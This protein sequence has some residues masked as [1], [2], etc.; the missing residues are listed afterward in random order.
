MPPRAKTTARTPS[1]SSTPLAEPLDLDA[2]DVDLAEQVDDAETSS[3]TTR[4]GGRRRAPAGTGN[5]LV[6][7]E[8]PAKAK[9]IAGYL[10]PGWQVESSIGHIR[11]LPRSAADVPAAHKGKPWA[12]LGVD[13]DN[14]F[15]PLYIVTPD[16]RPQVSKLKELVKDASELYL[17]TDEDREG[18][19]IAWHLLQTLKPTV[20]VKRMVFHEITPQAI[21]RAVDSPREIDENLVNAQETRRILDRLYGY[22]VS[23]VLW[24]KVMPRLSAGRVQS[25]AT[26]ILVERERARMRFRSADYWNIEGRFVATVGHDGKAP[27]TTPLPAT[28]VGLDGRRLVTGRDFDAT[29]NLTSTEVV[30]LDEAGAR[31][32]AERLAATTFAVRSVETKPYKRSPYPPFMTSTLQQEAGRKLRF[33]SQRTMQIAQKLYENGYITYMRTDSTNLSETALAAAREQAR[34]L[35]GPEY[36]PEKP[37]VYTKKVKN[38]QEAH[39]AIRP[40]GDTFRT[41]GEV[42]RELDTDGFRLYELIWQRTV[43]SQMADARGTSATVRLGGRSSTNEDAEFAATGK[44]I[45]FPGFLRAYVEGADDPDAELEDRETRLP[46]VRQGDQLATRDLTPRGHSTSPPPRFTEASLVKTLE[47]LG[48][49]RPSTYASIIGTIQDRGYVWKKGSALVPSFVAFAVVGLLED[50]FGRLVDYRFTASM[51]DDLDAI[52][53]GSSGSTDWLTRFYFGDDAADLVAASATNG[54]SAAPDPGL[55]HL[56]SER[57]GEIDARE[58]NSIPLGAAEDGLPVVVRVG[59]YGPYVQHGDGRASVPEDL[60]PD[61]LTIPKALELLDAPSGDRV[62]GTDPDNGATITAKAGRYGPYVTTDTEP[63]RTASLLSTMSLET[64][65]LDDARKLLTL[66]RVLGAGEDGEEITAQNG[67]YGPYVKH[68]TQSRSLANEEQ[69]FTV[70]LQ[71][72]LDLLA[73]PKTRG[74]RSAAEIPPLRE[75]G[76]DP[77]SGKPMV[78]KEGRFGPYVTDGET[79]ASLRKGDEID[80]LTIERAAELLADRRAR[81]PATPRRATARAGTKAPAKAGS[82]AKAKSSARASSA[83]KATA[84]T[85]T[86]TGTRATKRSASG[87]DGAGEG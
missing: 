1:R 31:G 42:R 20:P 68:G 3:G 44:V 11:D 60:P 37:R 67:R 55:K 87:A 2:E 41:P 32:L 27:D 18:E 23:P 81:G 85:T 86:K 65:T 28:L 52:A 54:K 29:G 43:A 78:L 83:A 35:Y 15:A 80:T 59:R 36:V 26:R 70:T 16:K 72:A 14:G 76:A 84:K 53:S 64:L 73:Q 61:E 50:H 58:V 33:S 77:T 66:P 40:S 79:N 45:T 69:L 62:L 46:D 71:E 38:A 5:R 13:V 9:T 25:V 49:G 82:T 34:Q 7:V 4:G 24:K 17:A 8:S 6:I 30:R 74:R 10:G 57:L 51:E 19:A 21:R 56:V 12:R 39:E 63:P 48:I 75:L 22:E 47:E